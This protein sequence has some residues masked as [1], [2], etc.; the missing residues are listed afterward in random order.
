[1]ARNVDEKARGLTPVR[2]GKIT[3]A[4]PAKSIKLLGKKFYQEAEGKSSA[5]N[6]QVHPVSTK[7]TSFEVG[8]KLYQIQRYLYLYKNIYRN[9][10]RC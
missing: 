6:Q 4:N 3:C 10:Y 5:T 2:N 7:S 1:M 8:C 9:I